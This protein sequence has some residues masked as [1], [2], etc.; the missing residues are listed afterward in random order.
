MNIREYTDADLARIT[1]MYNQADL[2]YALP[3]PDHF[4]SK[5]VVDSSDGVGMVAMMSLRAEA[6]LIC[7]PNWRS[8][9]WRA[10]ALKQ[11]HRVCHA[12]AKAA[13]VKEVIVFLPPKVKDQFGKRLTKM[14]WSPCRPDMPCFYMGVI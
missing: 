10:E 5:R 3:T 12:D 9:G 8:P 4:F 11:L 14:G 1:E 6:Y 7:D 13:G 2:D